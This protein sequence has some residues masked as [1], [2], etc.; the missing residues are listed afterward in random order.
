MVDL[1]TT[2]DRGNGPLESLEEYDRH[3]ENTEALRQLAAEVDGLADTMQVT[4]DEDI[5]LGTVK[6]FL[7]YQDEE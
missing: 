5:E 3:A 6:L 7:E 2:D 1:E 4:Y